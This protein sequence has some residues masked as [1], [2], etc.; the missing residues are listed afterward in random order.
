VTFNYFKKFEKFDKV[1]EFRLQNSFLVAIGMSL[2]APILITLKGTL[3]VAWVISVFAIFNMLAVKTN[4]YFVNNFSMSTLYRMGNITHFLLIISAGL[5]F[6]NPLLMIWLDSILVIT[7]VAIFSAYSIALTNYLTDNYPKDM[8]DFQIIRN[9][10]WADGALVGLGLITIVTFFFPLG[11]A[12]GTF[13]IFN[14]VFSLWLL[15]N[16]NFYNFLK[17]D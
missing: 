2:I 4:D 17:E 12:V 13:M 1:S 9:S 15:K 6:F 5:Y 14:T 8:K 11:Y 7:E 10:S 16:W 3:M